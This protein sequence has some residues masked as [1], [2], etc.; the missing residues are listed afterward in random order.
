MTIIKH[1]RAM[2]ILDC[3]CLKS[4]QTVHYLTTYNAWSYIY[5]SIF[6][7]PVVDTTF[8]SLKLYFYNVA[9]YF[10]I[11]FTRALDTT[12]NNSRAPVSR[13]N[14]CFSPNSNLF[15]LLLVSQ[16]EPLLGY[17]RDRLQG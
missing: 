9:M 13:A 10:K 3:Y 14:H 16:N 11:K 8:R 5:I 2:C 15:Y 6:V 1:K 17:S 12:Q 4:N 7:C